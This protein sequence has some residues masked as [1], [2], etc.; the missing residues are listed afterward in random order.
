MPSITSDQFGTWTGIDWAKLA[1]AR[2]PFHAAHSFMVIGAWLREYRKN[3]GESTHDRI[4]AIECDDDFQQKFKGFV[5]SF[6]GMQKRFIAKALI[7]DCHYKK[8][9]DHLTA[10]SSLPSEILYFIRQ[11]SLLTAFHIQK[12][13]DGNSFYFDLAF[14]CISIGHE[15]LIVFSPAFG[16]I[17]IDVNMLLHLIYEK[18]RDYGGTICARSIFS[19]MN[20]DMTTVPTSSSVQ[21]KIVE[22]S[23][24]Q[25]LPI[26]PEIYEPL[27]CEYWSDQIKLASVFEDPHQ[28]DRWKD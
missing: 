17:I 12:T 27:S 9:E 25:A 18:S 10:N 19:M 13:V 1:A 23:T 28:L 14:I 16:E 7:A 26:E 2:P 15:R 11:Y 3:P 24:L 6:K 8:V 22:L 20:L 5:D 21:S 4:D